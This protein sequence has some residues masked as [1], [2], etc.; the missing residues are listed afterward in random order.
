M[1]SIESLINRQILKW[2]T[3]RRSATEQPAASSRPVPPIVTVSRQAGSRGSYLASRLAQKLGYL[4]VDREAIDAI[5][6]HSGYVKRIV[7]S[8]DDRNRSELALLVEGVF[9]GQMVD[10]SDYFRHLYQVTLSMSRLGGVI[11]MGRGGNFI[12]G[13]NQGLHLRVV[14][15]VATRIDNL[16]RYR[17]L[18]ATQAQEYIAKSDSDRRQFIL[19]Q[20]N[21]DIDDPVRY[22][23]IANT[24]FLDVEELTETIST[25]LRAK[26]SK[27]EHMR[28]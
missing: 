14:A 6:S 20:F 15:P 9:A 27:L 16:V 19:R 2:E 26:M 28:D 10:H 23:L 13:Q 17:N 1:T 8:L 24:A 18:A 22:D 12:L 3:E 7:E 5:C 21:A 25:A 11:L 4:R